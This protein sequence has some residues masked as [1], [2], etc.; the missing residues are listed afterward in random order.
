MDAVAADAV[1]VDAADAPDAAVAPDAEAAAAADAAEAGA[2]AAC[3]GVGAESGAE[4]Q[5]A[6]LE[7][8][9]VGAGEI[10][11]DPALS[12]FRAVNAARYGT[13]GG[14]M[15]TGTLSSSG[16]FRISGTRHQ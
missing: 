9:I 3:R 7:N 5:R 13:L 14:A 2:A 6:S 8:A 1:A 11:N 12:L 15:V 16:S 10:C 4:R